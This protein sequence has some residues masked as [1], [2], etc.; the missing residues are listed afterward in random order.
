MCV[1]HAL[2]FHRRQRLYDAQQRERVWQ[3]P[4]AAGGKRGGGRHHGPWRDRPHAAEMLSRVW[5]QG[6][7]LEPSPKAIPGIETFHGPAGLDAFL[8]R[9]E[10]LVVPAAV[11]AARPKAFSISRCSA[12]SS[13][14]ARPAAPS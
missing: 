11:D 14:T 8:A 3:R 5:L 1:L 13:A 7:R 12:S 6:R 9:T 10:I 2:M 4:R